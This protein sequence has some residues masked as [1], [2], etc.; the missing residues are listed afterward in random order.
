MKKV[1]IDNLGEKRTIILQDLQN[2]SLHLQKL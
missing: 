1:K 2:L